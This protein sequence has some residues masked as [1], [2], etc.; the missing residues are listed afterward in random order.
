MSSLRETDLYAPVKKHLERQGYEVK[1]EVGAVDVMACRGDEPAVIV[2]LKTGFSLSLFHQAIARLTVTDL[3]YIAVPLS[4]GKRGAKS[5]KDNMALCKRLGLGLITVR[6][7]DK[8]LEVHCDPGAAKPRRSKKKK[9]KLL[10]EFSRRA[11]DPND[12][13]ATRHGLI[14]AYR[15]DAIRC[16]RFLAVH[17]ASKGA[18]VAE[19]AEVPT[20]TRVMRDNHYGWFVRVEK[21]IYT[22]SKQGR[23]GLSDYG[24]EAV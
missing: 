17:G 8:H 12:G 6:M 19:W 13:G 9:E 24:D 22:L 5:L 20:A 21:G 3:V 11:G 4:K 10:R 2:E 18:K 1:A 16:A 7:R 23:K 15:Q 14:T